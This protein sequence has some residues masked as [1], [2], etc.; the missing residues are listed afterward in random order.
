VR[1]SLKGLNE[2]LGKAAG[3]K[4]VWALRWT[5]KKAPRLVLP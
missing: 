5:S 1:N 4:P 2:Q 3:Y